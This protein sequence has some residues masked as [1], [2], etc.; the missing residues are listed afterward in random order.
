[1]T[2]K[3]CS[4]KGTGKDI[5]LEGHTA[6]ILSLSMDPKSEFLV[7]ISTHQY[8][9][10]HFKY[11]SFRHQAAVM[12]PS[13]SG[14]CQLESSFNLGPGAL[15]ATILVTRLLFAELTLSF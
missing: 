6:P 15:R 12:E 9:N 13:G 4:T 2:I 7:C 11:L 3:V 14:L 1:M 10:L 8:F 5:V